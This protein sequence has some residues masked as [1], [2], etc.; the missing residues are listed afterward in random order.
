M[1]FLISA[2]TAITVFVASNVA[3][4]A[5]LTASTSYIEG[6]HYTV[7]PNPV[8]TSSPGKIE[9]REFFWFGSPKSNAFDPL[10]RHWASQQSIDVSIVRTPAMWNVAMRFHAQNFFTIQA[11]GLEDSASGM[12]YHAMH[13]ERKRL[14]TNGEWMTLLGPLS[15]STQDYGRTFNSF[16][17]QSQVQ[18]A[19]AIAR[20]ARLQSLPMILVDGR[21]TV[22]PDSVGG[23]GNVLP[24]VDFLV[25]RER[26]ARSMSR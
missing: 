15:V 23:A 24:I 17:V 2:L 8:Q 25:A 18:Q 20:S 4:A 13:Q 14:S 5:Q 19:D 3:Q 7:L 11:L 1:K 6:T 9:V 16:G 21:Y 12:I 22:S 26:A 10:I